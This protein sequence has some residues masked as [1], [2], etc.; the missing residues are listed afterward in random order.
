M[1]TQP[2]V[3]TMTEGDHD[4]FTVTIP[5]V[6]LVSASFYELRLERPNGV[7]VKQGTDVGALASGQFLL[8]F[9]L[10]NDLVPGRMQRA[11]IR[12]SIAGDP[13][14][15]APFFINVDEKI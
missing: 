14:T 15:S 9:N 11:T 10:D 4:E 5:D 3:L 12:W 7:L 8:K 6:S 1:P 2:A 13:L